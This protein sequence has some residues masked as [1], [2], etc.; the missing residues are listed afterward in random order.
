MK[1]KM[2]ERFGA[3]FG[4]A[5]GVEVLEAPGRVNLIGGC[6]VNIVKNEAVESFIEKVGKAYKEKIGYDADFYVTEVGEGPGKL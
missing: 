1:Q 5:R 6:T 3:V 2:L 4:D